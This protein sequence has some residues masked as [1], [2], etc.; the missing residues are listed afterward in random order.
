MP[1][2]NTSMCGRAEDMK[3]SNA[4]W[5]RKD[6]KVKKLTNAEN[7]FVNLTGPALRSCQLRE[8]S[9]MQDCPAAKT[10]NGVI[11]LNCVGPEV[12]VLVLSWHRGLML[13]PIRG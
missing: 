8:G 6:N 7:D 1:N 9:S 5:W 2:R 12:A 11:L 10:L 13:H 3:R 4:Q